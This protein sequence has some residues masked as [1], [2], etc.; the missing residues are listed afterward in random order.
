MRRRNMIRGGL[1]FVTPFVGLLAFETTLAAQPIDEHSGTALRL[2]TLPVDGEP[3]ATL[4]RMSAGD[5]PEGPVNALVNGDFADGLTGWT[6][7][8]T[9]GSAAPGT[10]TPDGG[11]ALLLEGD[12]FIITL[13]QTFAI[14]VDAMTLSFDVILA[15]GFDLASMFI[16]DAFEAT[17]VDQNTQPVIPPWIAGATSFFNIQED[18]TVNVGPTTTAVDATNL[19]GGP[20]TLHVS[21]D[22][23][24]LAPG[25]VVTLFFDLIGADL[26]TAS[27]VRVDNVVVGG[28][29]PPADCNNNGVDDADDIAGGTSTDCDLN[30]VPDECQPD[31]DGDGAADA[32]EIIAGIAQDCDGNAV[33][34][35]CDI[36]A[37]VFPDCDGNGV[38]DVCQADCNA[39]G[40]PDVCDGGCGV[41]PG[42]GGGGGG[43]GP[44]PDQDADD[45]GVN[46]GIDSC[47]QT[48][49]GES[50]DPDGCSCGQ[51]DAD[52]DGVSDCDDQCAAT[53]AGD[54]ADAMGCSAAQR[55]SDG[56]GVVDAADLCNGA[57]DNADADGDSVPDCLDNC[58]DISNAAQDDGDGDGVGNACD[59]CPAAPNARDPL[60]GQQNDD[61][62]DGIGDACDTCPSAPDPSNADADADGLG[63]VC[64]DCDLGPND[65]RD[66]DAVFDACDLCPDDAEPTNADRDG[67]GIGDA[68]DNCPDATNADQADADSDGM[69]DACE[70]VAPPL[71]ADG[72][73]RADLADN[74]PTIAN[75]DQADADD[76]G[77]GDACDEGAPG[78]ELPPELE[79][80]VGG[81]RGCGIYNGVALI[82][83][84]LALAFGRRTRQLNLHP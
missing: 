74:C 51:V 17:L 67:D 59:N 41:P 31:C 63:D 76:D 54:A 49:L 44:P 30:G 79:L 11:Q 35:A 61:D 20:P 73:G 9:G 42:G 80:P 60:T 7:E 32:C 68:C 40:I 65:D 71:D 15:P 13:R 4:V 1:S 46:D 55:D 28:P 58:P 22:V 70:P 77:I 84:P 53:A 27:G 5:P 36:V 26:D 12:S 3:N 81:R 14:P 62:G 82:G 29:P 24:G 23:S 50:V 10:V 52:D 43:G 37:G 8:I 33:P 2:I 64:D 56:D 6:V 72:D 38:P 78:E 83:L 19:V 69:G 66:L 47:P 45:D 18:G 39:N 21:A 75:A 16:P 57:D 34:D 48:P 25:T